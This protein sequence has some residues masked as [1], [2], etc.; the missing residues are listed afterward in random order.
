MASDHLLEALLQDCH[1]ERTLQTYDIGDVEQRQAGEYLVEEP[2]VFLGNGRWQC[3]I[4]WHGHNGRG[5]QS[6]LCLAR[7]LN[8]GSHTGH[9]RRLKKAEEGHL[10]V[11][12]I[13]DARQEL[14]GEQRV[15]SQLKKVIVD[16]DLF[17]AQ[18]VT[19]DGRHLLLDGS[20]RRD[21]EVFESRPE[22]AG[23]G[24]SLAV[25][26]A[27]RCQRQGCQASQRPRGP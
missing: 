10:D 3:A 24:E 4:P 15:A 9:S 11:R 25:H 22:R 5:W 21:I 19:P 14:H 27:T 26:L 7:C 23:H 1:V 20:T 8:D 16:A 6:L 2:E 17:Q 12:G 18:E 13:A